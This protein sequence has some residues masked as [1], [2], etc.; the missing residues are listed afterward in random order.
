MNKVQKSVIYIGVSIWLILF[1]SFAMTVSRISEVKI[2]AGSNV[3]NQVP[4]QAGVI[5]KRYITSQISV[6]IITAACLFLFRT[7]KYQS[8][9]PKITEACQ[10]LMAIQSDDPATDQDFKKKKDEFTRELSR[11]F[12]KK[13]F[14]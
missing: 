6:L 7:R 5:Y 2:N 10:D 14:Y 1:L 12:L 8:G 11:Y 13:E 4:Y 9:F 3:E